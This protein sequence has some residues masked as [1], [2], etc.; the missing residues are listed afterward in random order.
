MPKG[1]SEISHKKIMCIIA[2]TLQSRVDR[3]QDVAALHLKDS[4]RTRRGCNAL[5]CVAASD[6]LA[7]ALEGKER[8][9][10]YACTK[11][12]LAPRNALSGLASRPGSRRWGLT[13]SVVQIA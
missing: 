6:G 7:A 2:K 10:F 8:Q 1:L 5:C 3:G 9:R 12:D 11:S 4:R 13:G